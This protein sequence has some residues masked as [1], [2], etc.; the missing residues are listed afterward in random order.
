MTRSEW[1]LIKLLA[2]LVVVAAL[3]PAAVIGYRYF[4]EN[5]L[6]SAPP[7]TP[8]AMFTLIPEPTSIIPTPTA[9]PPLSV[10]LVLPRGWVQYSV[11]ADNFAIA[12][13]GTWQRLPLQQQELD[14]SLQLIRQTNPELAAALGSGA[15]ELMRSGVKLWAYDSS[16][17]ALNARLATTLTVTH[18][19]LKNPVSFD[20]FVVVNVKQI[21]DLGSRVCDV[22]HEHFALPNVTAE[23]VRYN[24]IFRYNDG[25][26]LT[27]AITQYLV[28]SGQD[29]YTLTFAAPAD[30]AERV[31]ATFDQSAGT[32]RLLNP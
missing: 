3:F 7:P 32:F 16:A 5:Q 25:S 6:T 21:G 30:Q 23:R 22:T 15:Q 27:S 12:V 19:G 8:L 31:K 29:S 14:S 11:A 4:E 28:L 24:L 10:V 26:S 17:Q 18:Q 13:P 2:V 1:S 20:T 9:T